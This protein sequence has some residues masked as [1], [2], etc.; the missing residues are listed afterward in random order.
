VEN[1]RTFLSPLIRDGQLAAAFLLEQVRATDLH[2]RLVDPC[3]DSHRWG[4]SEIRCRGHA[5]LLGFRGVHDGAGQWVL[6]VRLGR[7][8]QGE[9]RVRVD[10]ARD[11][12]SVV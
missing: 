8:G 7:G 1:D 5:E 2:L 6:R 10:A 9:Q 11:R 12:K 3:A 4:R